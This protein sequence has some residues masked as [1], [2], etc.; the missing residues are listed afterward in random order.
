MPKTSSDSGAFRRI[1]EAA[2]RKYGEKGG[3]AYVEETVSKAK[4][5]LEDIAQA[6]KRM[7]SRA[8]GAGLHTFETEQD[9]VD[10]CVSVIGKLIQ[11]QKRLEEVE[12]GAKSSRSEASIHARERRK[13]LVEAT[14]RIRE[15]ISEKTIPPEKQSQLFDVEAIE[16]ELLSGIETVDAVDTRHWMSHEERRDFL[17][18]EAA[19]NPFLQKVIHHGK[20]YTAADHEVERLSVPLSE[21]ERDRQDARMDSDVEKLA[22]LYI[23]RSERQDFVDRV[24]HAFGRF[25]EHVREL[26]N[27]GTQILENE[28]KL[29]KTPE[30]K[31]AKRERRKELRIERDRILE[32][33]RSLA[34]ELRE[35]REL[36]SNKELLS[37][38]MKELKESGITSFTDA[39]YLSFGMLDQLIASHASDEYLQA[40]AK[41]K[42]VPE[43][44][45]RLQAQFDALRMN[46]VKPEL[47]DLRAS[48]AKKS[49]VSIRDVNTILSSELQAAQKVDPILGVAV[50]SE[51]LAREIAER[52]QAQ[53][54]FESAGTTGIWSLADVEAAMSFAFDDYLSGG[55]FFHPADG[56]IFGEIGSESSQGRVQHL[57]N[58]TIGA[59]LQGI[60]AAPLLKKKLL[61][62]TK[63]DFSSL[64]DI[65][66][67]HIE[68]WCATKEYVAAEITRRSMHRIKTFEEIEEVIH[69]DVVRG[70]KTHEYTKEMSRVV[71]PPWADRHLVDAARVSLRDSVDQSWTYHT[72]KF[73][74]ESLLNLAKQETSAGLQS[75]ALPALFE[76]LRVNMNHKRPNELIASFG[77]LID[78]CGR[79]KL[80]FPSGLFEQL[81]SRL[82][83]NQSFTVAAVGMHPE[84]RTFLEQ[85]I[86][87]TVQS[88]QRLDELKCCV[89]YYTQGTDSWRI[90]MPDDL[91]KMVQEKILGIIKADP[92]QIDWIS[93]QDAMNIWGED[94][95]DLLERTQVERVKAKTRKERGA[96]QTA[97]R[98]FAI[99][100]AKV[101]GKR[102]LL[103]IE[104]FQ[105]AN[106][107][108]A[109]NLDKTL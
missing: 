76:D 46:Q 67:D 52:D 84:I 85:K 6:K 44:E 33:A 95:G 51:H 91:K 61:I 26:R 63:P 22:Q 69:G 10:Y 53:E 93:L 25:D 9:K 86:A 7:D 78:L 16:A 83:E 28:K 107:A 18:Q 96:A 90:K 57:V 100:K 23:E 98:D 24:E 12:R 105:T 8:L 11:E 1:D 27:I 36:L 88:S 29:V 92:K 99:E 50:W 77:G 94:P 35:Q 40:Q 48:R 42:K 47:G 103:I 2:I 4:Q 19:M 97:L 108:L 41:R 62:R 3:L 79:A 106:P 30:E 60:K 87:E 72:G 45:L 13:K 104:Y 65:A 38:Q 109:K 75:I 89:R 82:V 55:H 5:V 32:E 70:Y 64:V 74:A 102:S 21:K 54:F 56:L 39:E 58:D 81:W 101:L 14:T 66:N 17:Q 37:I 59:W 43:E 31:S 15:L 68:E 49:T 73:M 20:E 80:E 34:R 71:Y